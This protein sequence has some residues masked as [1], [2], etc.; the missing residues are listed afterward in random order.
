MRSKV[1]Q[2][3]GLAEDKVAQLDDFENSNAFTAREKAALRYATAFKNGD[4]G[5]DS[6]DVYDQLRQHFSEEE[7]VELGLFCAETDGAG[8]FVRS[9]QVLSWEEACQIN[10]LLG[11]IDAKQAAE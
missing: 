3:E 2:A 11:A 1:A 6:D 5:V 8:K 10:P 9:L 7:I 4:D